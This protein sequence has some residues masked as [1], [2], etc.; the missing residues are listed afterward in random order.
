VNTSNFIGIPAQM[1]PEQE[2]LVF[3]NRRLTYGQLWDTV[4]R[5]VQMRTAAPDFIAR[6]PSYLIPST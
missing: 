1:F 6:S 3:E 4:R 5:L 2:I